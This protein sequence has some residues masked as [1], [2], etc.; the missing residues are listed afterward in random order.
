MRYEVKKTI[1]NCVFC[2]SLIVLPFSPA[3]AGSFFK[4]TKP[5]E[6]DKKDQDTAQTQPAPAKQ[7]TPKQNVETLPQAAAAANDAPVPVASPEEI[8][9]T[10][11]IARDTAT[12]IIKLA[13]KKSK[14]KRIILNGIEKT[15]GFTLGDFAIMIAQ[16]GGQL[17]CSPVDKE[18]YRCTM[19]DGIDIAKEAL[20][21]GLTRALKT[22]SPDY[23]SAEDEARKARIGIWR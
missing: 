1:I 15:T 5:A 8:K 19:P 18:S 3:Q 11:S 9:G 21:N 10:L 16:K 12:V 22:A 13:G 17:T 20:R 6:T 23:L 14:Q 7:D 4:E 2:I